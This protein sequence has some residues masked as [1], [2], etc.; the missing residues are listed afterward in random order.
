VPRA[1]DYFI[2]LFSRL[3]IGI[4]LFTASVYCLVYTLSLHDALPIS[5]LVL[6]IL[7]LLTNSEIVQI[8]L[9][10]ICCLLK[11]GKKKD[12]WRRHP[13]RSEEHT[14]ELQSRFELVCRLLLEKKKAVA[15]A[16]SSLNLL[17]QLVL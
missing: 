5:F 11:N 8:N 16:C 6:D 4:L 14:S 2:L 17:C 15:L 3:I 1:I 13:I 10:Q 7:E 9:F 12:A